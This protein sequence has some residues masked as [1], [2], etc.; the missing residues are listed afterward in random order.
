MEGNI[1]KSCLTRFILP[2]FNHLI[3]NKAVGV[4]GL[5]TV[6]NLCNAAPKHLV[7]I[8]QRKKKD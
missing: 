3:V 5:T 4:R 7:Y 8:M 2:N 6:A 1:S